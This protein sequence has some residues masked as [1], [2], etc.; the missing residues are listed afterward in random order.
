MTFWI[1][2]CKQGS[3][4]ASI[5]IWDEHLA[6]V[7]KEGKALTLILR[8]KPA[9]FILSMLCYK[10][11]ILNRSKIG[12]LK[13][14]NYKA[15]QIKQDSWQTWM[16]RLLCTESY[17]SKLGSGCYFGIIWHEE[18]ATLTGI[19]NGSMEKQRRLYIRWVMIGFTST[20]VDSHKINV[21]LTNSVIYRR[22]RS[23]KKGMVSDGKHYIIFSS[24]WSL[25]AAPTQSV[26]LLRREIECD[27]QCF[28]EVSLFD[29]VS[30]VLRWP[31]INAQ[32]IHS[33]RHAWKMP[34]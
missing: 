5:S 8:H 24:T 15:Y 32:G 9:I 28:S 1:K 21:Q 14:Y 29:Y 26:C 12:F 13:L 20:D 30:P 33:L 31:L 22:M 2:S 4:E 10:N 3:Y 34:F 18:E 19:K 7:V 23:Q 25:T 17:C 16:R 27:V 6:E 11:N